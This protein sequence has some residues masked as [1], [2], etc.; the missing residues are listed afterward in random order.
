M[1]I[2]NWYAIYIFQDCKVSGNTTISLK[3]RDFERD[4]MFISLIKL[5]IKLR[6][7]AFD[8][9]NMNTL[10]RN[11]QD[12]QKNFHCISFKSLKSSGSRFLSSQK[13]RASYL[14][15]F[16]ISQQ[17]I[18]LGKKERLDIGIAG[19]RDFLTNNQ[20]NTFVDQPYTPIY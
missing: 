19:E 9:C 4:N 15:F 8:K 13:G 11:C 14:F 20:R 2:F 17:R 5:K 18:K 3:L 7:L 10:V 6:Y 1:I 12:A 16:F